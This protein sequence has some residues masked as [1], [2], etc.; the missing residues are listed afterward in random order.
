MKK[1]YENL[2]AE[3]Q[4]AVL[5]KRYD[6]AKNLCDKAKSSIMSAM[7]SEAG[8]EPLDNSPRN[9]DGDCYEC[10]SR[11]DCS[12]LSRAMVALS[13]IQSNQYKKS[14]LYLQMEKVSLLECQI[15][16]ILVDK[17]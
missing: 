1:D 13:I 5:N 7:E 2:I 11:S 8:I 3:A 16:K 10:G 4:E 6:F 15:N 17:K 9:C 12:G 14:E